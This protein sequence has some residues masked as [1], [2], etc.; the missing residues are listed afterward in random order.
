MDGVLD[1]HDGTWLAGKDGPPGMIMPADVQLGRHT[2]GQ[3]TC[4]NATTD[5]RLRH[6]FPAAADLN[7]LA[8]IHARVAVDASAGEMPFVAGDAAELQAIWDRVVH[9]AADPAA[10]DGALADLHTAVEAAD[11]DAASGAADQLRGALADL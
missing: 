11:V 9:T 4:G 5:L 2:A 1:N 8:L 7:Q 6:E 3:P 10:V